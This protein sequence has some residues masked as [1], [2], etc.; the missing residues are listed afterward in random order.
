[1]P[2]NTKNNYERDG[3]GQGR[4]PIFNE[5]AEK[6]C[7]PFSE[8]FLYFTSGSFP[9]FSVTLKRYQAAVFPNRHFGSKILLFWRF[10]LNSPIIKDLNSGNTEVTAKTETFTSLMCLYA[11]YALVLVMSRQ[12][13][14]F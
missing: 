14:D 8:P 13:N 3:K 12:N 6:S 5:A 7:V 4:N 1:M 9:A 2:S 10:Y 11:R